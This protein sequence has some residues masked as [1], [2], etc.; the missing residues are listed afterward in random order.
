LGYQPRLAEFEI[1]RSIRRGR[2][3]IYR[4]PAKP[5]AAK[6]LAIVTVSWE[7]T[8]KFA[9]IIEYSQ[10]KAK[11]AE[12]RPTHRQ[13]LGQLKANGQL[14]AAGPFTDDSGALII[15]E[16]ASKED[17]EKLLQGDPFHANGIF[18]RWQ[19]RPWN[20]VIVNRDL[21]PA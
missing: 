16:A 21:F 4:W 7:K 3:W 14:A 8:M 20:P 13:Y 19:L 10:D 15:Y 9:A 6:K 17:A 11:I 18:L 2:R 1:Q 5:P 12:I